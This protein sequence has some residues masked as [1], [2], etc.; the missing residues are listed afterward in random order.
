VRLKT[1]FLDL[2]RATD[3]LRGELDEAYRRV[4]DSGWFVLGPE[5][6]AFE[7]EFADY[8][9][10]R[11]CVAVG[12]GL[13]ALYLI[14]RASGIGP[15]DEVIVPAH[16]FIATWLAVS[17]TGAVP[18]GADVDERTFN[19]DPACAEAAVTPRTA[20]ILPVHLYGQPAD[21][22]ALAQV[23]RRHGLLLIEDAAQ[24]HG[25]SCHG[26]R[27]GNL[28][29]AAAFSFYPAKNLGALGDGGAVT[30]DDGELAA[31]VR[32]LRNYGSREKYVHE[33]QGVN[34]RL[35]ELQAA[36]LRVKLRHLDKWNARRADLAARYARELAGLPELALPQTPA[37]AS[38]VWHLYVVRH[39]RRDALQQHLQRLGVATLI[40]YPI[41]PHRSAAYQGQRGPARS[42]FPVTERLAGEIL[43]LPMSP[44][45]S[46]QE[47]AAAVA[48]IRGF[49][50]QRKLAG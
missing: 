41:P 14:L 27:A 5:L 29:Q 36:L 6:E 43:S 38:P 7:R 18:V 19:L 13:D 30:T 24:A 21:V 33:R 39:P 48:A 46:D 45:H 15:G 17:A 16:T 22:P 42:F 12:N 1:P 20:A 31:A 4:A 2:K 44:H 47:V 26:K 37:W 11:H 9:G 23:A 8:C 32:L 40:H 3:E 35:D 50:E 28:G 25:A 34:S 10:A 49:A